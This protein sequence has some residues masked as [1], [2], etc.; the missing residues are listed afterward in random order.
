M[1]PGGKEHSGTPLLKVLIALSHSRYTNILQRTIFSLFCIIQPFSIWASE[2]VIIWAQQSILIVPSLKLAQPGFLILAEHIR[3]VIHFPQR[4]QYSIPVQSMPPI[5][6]E[7][8]SCHVWPPNGQC[9]LTLYAVP[10]TWGNSYPLPFPISLGHF[11]SRLPENISKDLFFVYFC[12]VNFT[13]VFLSI[14]LA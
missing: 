7:A 14:A 6:A 2:Q 9:D 4:G 1:N 8:I 5:E 12:M 10:W 11:F 13:V 3:C